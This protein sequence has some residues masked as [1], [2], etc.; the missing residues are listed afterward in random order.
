LRCS[1]LEHTS[2]WT[3][4]EKSSP[5]LGTSNSYV[6]STLRKDFEVFCTYLTP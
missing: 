4:K 2:W 1:S 5:T 3:S 6:T